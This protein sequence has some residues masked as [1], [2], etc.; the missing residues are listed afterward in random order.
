[1]KVAVVGCGPS[2][3]QWGET[4]FELSIGVNDAIKWGYKLDQ[5][6]LVNF[7]RKF[8][9]ERL[10]HIIN[11]KAKVWTHTSAWNKHFPDSVI[12]KLTSFNGNIRNDLIYC[13]K[14]S[15]MVAMSLAIKQGASEITV[16]GVDMLT[17]QAY[18][19]GTKQG[20]YEIKKYIQFFDQIRKRGVKLYR[21]ADGSIFDQHLPLNEICCYHT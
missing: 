3:K 18:R 13:S 1:M 19:A 2:A 12:I 5:L 4:K 6:V 16:F 11:T 14:T 7:Q 17:H 10:Q 8:T 15:P 21:G 20:D 9:H